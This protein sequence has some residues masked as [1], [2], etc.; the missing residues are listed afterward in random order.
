VIVLG[1]RGDIRGR[2]LAA[3]LGLDPSPVTRL[4]SSQ[5]APKR[6]WQAHRGEILVNLLQSAIPL[7][8]FDQ[9]L[10]ILTA[11]Q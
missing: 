1:R 4:S 7:D 11:C 9:I 2:V 8:I 10:N 5:A 6:R 3:A